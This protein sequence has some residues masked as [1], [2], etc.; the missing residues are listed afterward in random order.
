MSSFVLSVSPESYTFRSSNSS[1]SYA[2]CISRPTGDI[3]LVD[4]KAI[5]NVNDSRVIQGILGIVRLRLNKYV[6]LISKTQRVGVIQ[7]QPLY[8]VTA[9]DLLPVRESKSYDR[10]ES[11]Y[12]D[13]LRDHLNSAQLCFSPNYDLSNTLQRQQDPSYDAAAPM[14]TRFDSRFFWNRHICEDLIDLATHNDLASSFIFPVIFGFV[15]IADTSINH[16]PISFGLISRRSR[17][18]AGTR[19]FRR[20]I[21]SDGNVANFNETEQ[22]LFHPGSNSFASFV[23]TRGSV[24]VYWGEV[25]D[26]KYKPRLRVRACPDNAA[27]KHF[28]EQVRLYGKNY[29]VNLVNQN[30][31]E[32]PIKEAYEHVVDALADEKNLIYVYFDFHHECSKMRWH[33]VQLLVDQ[34]VGLG[35]N[36][37]GWCQIKSMPSESGEVKPQVIK[38]QTSVV[39][40][41]CMDCLDR[42]NVVQSTLGRWVLLQQMVEIGVLPRGSINWTIDQD[43]FELIFRNVWADNANAVS[44]AYSGTG[45]LKT[46]FTRLGKRTKWGAL[47]DFSNSA[48]RYV[49]NNFLD[50]KRQ[51]SF[52]LFLGNHLPYENIEPHFFDS[53]PVSVQ[54]VPYIIA[55][56]ITMLLAGYMFPKKSHSP[57]VN[58][59]FLFFWSV[60]LA[61]SINYV[62][63]NG[64]QYV[65][66]PKLV[67]L[68]FVTQEEVIKNGEVVGSLM[69]ETK[70][71]NAEILEEGK[72]RFD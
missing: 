27:R 2:L 69:A 54:S 38:L 59:L 32:S 41:N 31:Y 61:S 51:D 28:D 3:S 13:L 23:Q 21:D 70:G 44:N 20:G 25:I 5:A 39:R 67:P 34:L 47:Q 72:A 7:G 57:F 40:T 48:R 62:M 42:T 71:V 49:K 15:E 8:R 4:G 56:S 45:A 6:V 53:R 24:P 29:L 65:S 16:K 36:K 64:L 55:S 11:Q 22:L 43:Q 14:W 9:C 60:V 35:L 58:N 50:G 68:E 19:Y 63:K 17:F 33:R 46:D 10:F 66:W 12:L 37:Q 30:G 1:L 52:D 26:L 18:R